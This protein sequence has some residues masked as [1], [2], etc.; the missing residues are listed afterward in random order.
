MIDIQWKGKIGYGDIVSPLCYAHN[1]SNQ[2]KQP[3]V[4]TFRWD[5][6]ASKKI[7]ERDPETLWER[8]SFLQTTLRPAD[9]VVKHAFNNPLD[10]NHTNYDWKVVSKDKLHNYWFVKEQYQHKPRNKLIVFNTTL[11]NE[12]SLAEYGKPWK[13]PLNQRWADL[14]RTLSVDLADPFIDVNY[15]TPIKSLVG[16]LKDCR[17]FIGYHGTAA[18][19]AR[20]LGVP[21]IIIANGGSLTHGSF[22]NALIMKDIENIPTFV[23]DLHIHIKT[24]RN[25]HERCVYDYKRYKLPAYIKEHLTIL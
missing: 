6:G 16:L 25:I 18:W 10:I 14:K 1:I 11:S 20:L 9:V 4:L 19:V 13:D 5:H 23:R 3:V 15:Q 12:Q 7:S 8:V 17:C 24:A 2:L 21:S 22:P